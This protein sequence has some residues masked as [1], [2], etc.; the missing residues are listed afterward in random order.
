LK[1][2]KFLVVGLG[3]MGK[4]RIRNLISLGYKNIIG[5]DIREDRKN[6]S[7]ETETVD[8][9]Q[10]FNFADVSAMFVSVP[11]DEHIHYVKMAY[12]NNVHCFI[13]AS[14]VDDGLSDLADK[15]EKTD[16]KFYASCTMRFHPAVKKIKELVTSGKIGALSNF[17]YHSGQYLPDWHPW[18]DIRDFYVSKRST[19]GCREIVPFELSWIN[20]VFGKVRSLSG[21]NGKTIN[22]GVDI[23]DVYGIVFQYETGVIGTLIVDVVSRTAIR[24]LVINGDKGQLCWN[25][26]DDNIKLYS[27]DSG[28][29]EVYEIVKGQS[30]DGYNK[31]IAEDMYIEEVRVFLESVFKNQPV[32]NSLRD[33]LYTLGCLYAAEKSQPIN[34]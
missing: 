23:D 11:P 20:D 21:I 14:V 1:N 8:T 34:I 5:Y 32:C 31:N 17:S 12:E 18:E 7:A 25:W 24:Q 22:L 16:L 9:L 29:W 6:E 27:A 4:R 2:E 15:I 30:A 13:E 33:D 10:G 28:Q 26:N 3:S 19:G